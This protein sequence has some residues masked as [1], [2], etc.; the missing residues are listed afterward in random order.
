M[1]EEKEVVF[2]EVQRFSLWL[3]LFFVASMLFGV[4]I[5]VYAKATSGSLRE[6]LPILVTAG[7][8]FL[9]LGLAVFF[10]T[11]R[12][13]TEVRPDGIYFRFFP[14]QIHYKKLTPGELVD[15]YA[16]QYRPILEYGGW[17]IRCG[18]RG[19]RAYNVSGD[20]GVQLVLGDGRQL[21]I[22]SQ[23]SDQLAEAICS[24]MTGRGS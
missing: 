1:S 11:M 6:P 7:L 21:L 20:R 2:R 12:L 16:R 13:E 17:G 14:M 22:G 3:R 8:T 23:K 15:C 9:L 18:F 5:M 10:F 19:G 4:T 24:L